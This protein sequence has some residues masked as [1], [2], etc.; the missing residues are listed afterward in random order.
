MQ[1]TL[2]DLQDFRQSGEGSTGFSYDCISDSNLMVKMYNPEYPTNQIVKEVEL[3]RKVYNLGVPSPEPGT[4]V[5][6]GKRTGIAFRRIV[7]KRSF[8]RIF[9]DEPERIEEFSREFA[10][11]SLKLHSIECPPGLLPDIKDEYR[12]MLEIDKVFT[13][14][15]KQVILDH[16]RDSEDGNKALHGDLHFGNII[17]NIPF[18]APLTTPHDVYFIDLGSFCKG[19]PYFDL[20]ML[21]NI[22]LYSDDEYLLH[23]FHVHRSAAVLCWEA[24]VDEYFGGK[25]TP[26]QAEELL[27]PY[28]ALKMILVDYLLGG[29][30][31]PDCERSIRSIFG[32]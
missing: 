3:A 26:G 1:T 14:A 23:D 13:N 19:H 28:M 16:I 15:E 27:R 6:D 8:S 25:L 32:L 12:R 24:F 17:S 29:V 30:L 4:L 31:P 5:T 9:A 18:G 11:Y 10:R 22:C 21:L 2:I 7:G 20:G